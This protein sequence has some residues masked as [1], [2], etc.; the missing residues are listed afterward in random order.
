MRSISSSKISDGNFRPAH[1]GVELLLA[2]LGFYLATSI[3]VSVLKADDGRRP[4]AWHEHLC[5][6]ALCKRPKPPAMGPT[7]LS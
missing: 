6:K 4:G 5:V 2:S 3:P 7:P 1:V